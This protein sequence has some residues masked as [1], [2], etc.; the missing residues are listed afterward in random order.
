MKKFLFIIILALIGVGVW[1][2]FFRGE[3]AQSTAVQYRTVPISRATIIQEVSATGTIQPI[4]K[5]EVG[6]Q[7]T[8]KILKLTADFNSNVKSGELLAR[9]DPATYQAQFDA[10][11]AQ[12]LSA[13][14]SLKSAEANFAVNQ[15]KLKYALKTHER[16]LNLRKRLP[17]TG[18]SDAD[19]EASEA[20]VEQLRAQ[21]QVNEADIAKSKAALAQAE[22]S[23]RQA[24]ANLGYCTI[25]SPIDGVVIARAVDEG[26]T[27]VSNMN[28]STLFTLATD[29]T[30]IQVVASIPE[31]D[32]GQVKIGQR[33]E[34]SVDAY[35]KR[36]FGTVS[37]IRLDAKT[38]SNV[39]TYP[40]IVVADNPGTAL[41]PGMTANLS[42]IIMERKNVL[43]VPVAALRFKGP[44]QMQQ[45][46]GM[47]AG[48]PPKM[49]MPPAGAP[50]Q[51]GMP[52]AGAPQQSPKMPG[53]QRPKTIWITNETGTLEAVKVTTGASDGVNTEIINA[54]ELEGKQAV[55][56]IMTKNDRRQE[57]SNNPFAMKPPSRAPKNAQP[58]K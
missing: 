41:F 36:F 46:G 40:V 25:Y 20:T 22:A 38:E 4:K 35:P 17:E 50:P 19:L 53:M 18:I 49:G 24:E 11:R 3:Q 56:G 12:I 14:A 1:W 28:T 58:Q 13:E 32:I 29:L 39:V 30:K 15:S 31:A 9:I 7:V 57:G 45:P 51:M 54:D 16:N 43:S 44:Q 48:G 2:F 42:I 33:V 8:G 26:Q 5:V 47:P 37:E 23:G 21:I 52:P 55:T 6:T 27:V 34:F 10:S